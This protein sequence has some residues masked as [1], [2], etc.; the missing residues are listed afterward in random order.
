[1]TPDQ[2]A[3]QVEADATW[4]R[5]PCPCGSRNRLIGWR[6]CRCRGHQTRHCLDCDTWSY[7]PELGERCRDPRM[8]AADGGVTT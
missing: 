1:M 3:A 5:E 8:G 7:R 2:L 4:R 6:P